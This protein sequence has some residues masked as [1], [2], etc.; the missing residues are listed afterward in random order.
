MANIVVGL[1]NQLLPMN[2][3]SPYFYA[4]LDGLK[5]AGNNVL[6]FQRRFA[7]TEDKTK[8]P[9]DILNQIRL[10]QPDLFIFVCNQFW[11]VTPYFD[12]PI[13]VL[14]VDSINVFQNLEDLK[15]KKDRYAYA[16][17]TQTGVKNIL[18]IIK[19]SKDKV[20]Y[21]QPFTEIHPTNAKKRIPI[22]FCGNF[23]LWDD[24][25]MVQDFIGKEPT[26]LERERAK[27]VFQEFLKFPYKK[28]QEFSPI[29]TF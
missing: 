25:T 21:F 12:Q 22:G 2:G 6:C 9:P 10:F 26:D 13:I 15:T 18:D 5:E 23:F 8:I 24:F 17:I 29:S 3:L 16:S 11:D 14:D 27:K 19:P 1:Y 4:L 7:K 28:P 20:K